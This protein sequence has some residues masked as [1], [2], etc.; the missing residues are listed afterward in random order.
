MDAYGILVIILSI[1]LA[2]F[3]ILAIILTSLTIKLVKQLRQIAD[4][5]EHIVDN[6]SEIGETIKKNAGAAVLVKTVTELI[7]KA[8]SKSKN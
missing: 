7:A 4:K 6:V 5:G 8:T 1:T 3:L 2:I